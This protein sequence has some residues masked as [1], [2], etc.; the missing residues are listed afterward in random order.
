M[1]EGD[2]APRLGVLGLLAVDKAFYRLVIIQKCQHKY[3]IR[4]AN[5]QQSIPFLNG[6]CALRNSKIGVVMQRPD[7]HERE[8]P[9][10]FHCPEGEYA[11]M[12]L[13]R[14]RTGMSGE[15]QH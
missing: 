1:P 2:E 3:R 14:S 7:Q 9:L 8:V 5:T 13:F 4:C 15:P 12:D 11:E 6:L 10:R